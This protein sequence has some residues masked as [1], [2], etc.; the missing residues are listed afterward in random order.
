[1]RFQNPP[2]VVAQQ[3]AKVLSKPKDSF[4]TA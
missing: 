3:L 2:G 1:L 4:I